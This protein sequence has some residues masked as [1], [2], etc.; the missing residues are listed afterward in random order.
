MKRGKLWPVLAGAVLAAVCVNVHAVVRSLDLLPTPQSITAEGGEMLRYML[1][2]GL[3][4]RA[5]PC[6]MA[7]ATS[8]PGRRQSGCF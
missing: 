3:A 4:M 2:R 8:P 6:P 1:D 7:G 5:G